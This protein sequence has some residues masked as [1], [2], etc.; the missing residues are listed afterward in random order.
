MAIL[1]VHESDGVW[2]ET[3]LVSGYVSQQC[4]VPT[5]EE[6]LEKV[7]VRSGYEG[8]TVICPD[9]FQN[10]QMYNS[11]RERPMIFSAVLILSCCMCITCL[12]ANPNQ[13]LMDMQ[14]RDWMIAVSNW[15]SSPWGRLNLLSWLSPQ[16]WTCSALEGQLFDLPSVHTLTRP[17]QMR[18]KTIVLSANF[19]SLTERSPEGLSLEQCG[20]HTCLWGWF[21]IYKRAPICAHSLINL[22]DKYVCICLCLCLHTLSSHK[23]TVLYVWPPVTFTEHKRGGMKCSLFPAVNVME[24]NHNST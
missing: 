2:T 13:T 3:V 17:S 16:I 18:P 24:R 6:R 20:E 1:T 22:T 12:V 4:S 23:A 15:I 19:R 14:R 8:C 10:Q 9:C 7:T 21:S 11:W 5:K